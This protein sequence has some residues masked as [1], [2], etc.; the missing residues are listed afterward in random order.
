MSF[1]NRKPRRHTVCLCRPTVNFSPSPPAACVARERP[2]ACAPPPETRT[3]SRG[4]RSTLTAKRC[5]RY[6][7]RGDCAG[8]SSWAEQQETSVLRFHMARSAPLLRER[9]L[10]HPP[11]PPPATRRTAM[12]GSADPRGTVARGRHYYW[13]RTFVQ[14][15]E[16]NFLPV[17]NHPCQCKMVGVTPR[18]G[19]PNPPP[20]LFVSVIPA[21]AAC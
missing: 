17:T 12:G 13:F 20:C 8:T 19:S 9:L 11:P 18:A 7:S 3:R 21:A 5:S 16:M 2:T 6:A 4:W 10:L 14:A 1:V 15:V